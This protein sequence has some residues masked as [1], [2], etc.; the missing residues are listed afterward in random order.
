MCLGHCGEV[1]S[2][3][4][5]GVT[6][7]TDGLG[8]TLLSQLMQLVYPQ[9]ERKGLRR[10]GGDYWLAGDQEPMLALALDSRT[11]SDSKRMV[12]C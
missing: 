4:L 11:E 10:R 3:G 7:L 2:A 12:N 9:V 8:P 1:Q 6:A 5:G